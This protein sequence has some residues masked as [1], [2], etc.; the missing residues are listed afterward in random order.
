MI[1]EQDW[2]RFADVVNTSDAVMCATEKRSELALAMM[3]EVLTD[4]SFEEVSRAVLHHMK[5]SVYPIKPADIVGYIDGDNDSRARKAWNTLLK[6]V[7]RYG[8]GTS[9]Y[10][11]DP[12]IHYVLQETGD[13]ISFNDMLSSIQEKEV[14]FR[15]KPF[16]EVYL[17]GVKCASF[18]AAAGKYKV[19]P[20]FLG[21]YDRENQANGYMGRVKP[22]VNALTGEVWS[23]NAIVA[24]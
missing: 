13:W 23:E 8:G 24:R 9:V 7:H 1:K 10:F 17:E 22:P 19:K 14:E 6:A 4:Y 20:Y 21:R 11:D 15:F 18:V 16:K 12:A 3:F 5:T 2:K